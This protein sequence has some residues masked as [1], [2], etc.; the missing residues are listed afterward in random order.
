MVY[1]A[2]ILT[3]NTELNFLA[4]SRFWLIT[5]NHFLHD[6]CIYLSV[7]IAKT[8]IMLLFRFAVRG[9]VT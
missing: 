3:E 6:K 7:M 4:P 2:G 8:H 5:L 1:S 9:G